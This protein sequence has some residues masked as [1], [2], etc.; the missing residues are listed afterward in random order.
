[1]KNSIK[2]VAILAFILIFSAG[3]NDA[4]GQKARKTE[5]RLKNVKRTK[6]VETLKLS[7]SEKNRFNELNNK[8]ELKINEQRKEVKENREK[9]WKVVN[10]DANSNETSKITED[11]LNSIDKMHKLTR[12]RKNDFKNILNPTQYAKFILYDHKFMHDVQKSMFKYYKNNGKNMNNFE[13]KER[14]YRNKKDGNCSK[15]ADGNCTDP[16]CPKHKKK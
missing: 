1:M 13:M 7:E 10:D 3:A 16:N 9:L 5:N 2:Y 8:W 12:E 11:F 15:D 14:K 4:F 6:L